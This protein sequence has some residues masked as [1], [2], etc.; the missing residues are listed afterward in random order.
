VPLPGGKPRQPQPELE[1]L[2]RRLAAV[3]QADGEELIADNLLL[4]C[5]QLGDTS[6]A[7]L[8]RQR[9]QDA[10]TIVDRYVWIGAGV[11]ALTP[12]PGVDLLGAAAVNAQMVMEIGKVYG[13]SL[14]RDSAQDLALSVGR[15]LAGLGLV[16][17]GVALISSVISLSLPVLLVS[18]AIQAVTAAWL[19]R[20]AGRS[21]IVFFQQDQDWGDGGLQSVLQREYD[22]NRREDVLRSFLKTA[23]NRV[24]EPLQRRQVRLPPRPPERS[25]APPAEGGAADR[26][27]RAP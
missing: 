11:V 1:A 25:Q 4:Q 10:E 27:Y 14:S 20:V 22:L 17:G 24:V 7:L 26:D 16:K 15:T 3:L 9:H 19:T 5:R 8:D 18:R 6:R 23:V 12:L 13:V 21:F 2:L